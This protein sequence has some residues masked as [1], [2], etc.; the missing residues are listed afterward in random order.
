MLLAVSALRERPGV[1]SNFRPAGLARKWR[2]LI[3]G[4][5][6]GLVN[7]RVV[8]RCSKARVPRE[9][10]GGRSCLDDGTGMP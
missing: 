7:I 9:R 6:L 1:D 10:R 4:L 8:S 3:G 2:I 5:K